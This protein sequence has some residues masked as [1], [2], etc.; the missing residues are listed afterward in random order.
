MTSGKQ[1][2]V[3]ESIDAEEYPVRTNLKVMPRNDTYYG[4]TEDEIMER[5][6]HLAIMHSTITDPEGRVNTQRRYDVLADD[7]FR[8]RLLAPVELFNKTVVFVK[9]HIGFFQLSEE[10]V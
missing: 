10:E 8:D 9:M 5:L 7:E 3:N 2:R 6:R 1:R 4:L